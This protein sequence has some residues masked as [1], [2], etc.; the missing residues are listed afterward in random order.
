MVVGIGLNVTL[1]PDKLPVP[2]ATS[3]AIEQAACVDRDPLLLSLLRTLDS[4]VRSWCE[5]QGVLDTAGFYITMGG[6]MRRVFIRLSAAVMF[7][8]M[9]LAGVNP[10]ARA[11]EKPTVAESHLMANCQANA[12]LSEIADNFISRCRQGSIRRE[13]PAEHLSRTLS[14]IKGDSSASGK[15]AWKL[16][17]DKR[18]LKDNNSN[19][20]RR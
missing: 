16:L 2:D 11:L 9:L 12:N 8:A 5:H 3:L 18:F 15:K 14:S 4:A 1:R 13:F 20:R 10:A 19:R 6:I 17:N 7:A